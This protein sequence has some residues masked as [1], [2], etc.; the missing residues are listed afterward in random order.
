MV[1]LGL[2]ARRG[3]ERPANDAE[4]LLFGVAPTDPLALGRR[5]AGA[6]RRP[7]SPAICPPAARRWWIR[8]W[9]SGRSSADRRDYWAQIARTAISTASAERISC[10]VWKLMKVTRAASSRRRRAPRAANGAAS[11]AC[12]PSNIAAVCSPTISRVERI[13]SRIPDDR[14]HCLGIGFVV[15]VEHLQPL[16]EPRPGVGHVAQ[17]ARIGERMALVPRARTGQEQRSIVGKMPV[18]GMPLN[19]RPLR[20]RAHRGPRRPQRRVQRDCRVDDA[21]ARLVLPLGTALE[22]VGSG[23]QQNCC[24]DVCIGTRV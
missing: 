24:T 10:H 22:S 18:E 2:G 7:A 6:V 9:R 15:A 21:L 4:S 19:P 13:D 17:R 20:N 14:N 16:A 8:W 5:R 3:G 11:V 12:K 1:G 23:H